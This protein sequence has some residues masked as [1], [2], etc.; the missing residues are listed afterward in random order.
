MDDLVRVSNASRHSI[1]SEFGGKRDLFLACFALYQKQ[2][3]TPAFAPVEAPDAG[4][5]EIE[6][7]F[8]MQISRAEK[9]GLP[10][11]GCLVANTATEYAP[12]DVDAAKEVKK[13]N[14]RLRSGFAN[15]LP[16]GAAEKAADTLVV[17][18][19]GLWTLSRIT[20]DAD[21]LRLT[22]AQFLKQFK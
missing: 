3:V 20:E 17:F 18:A 7:Y 12:H 21:H 15:A 5:A 11:P 19:T 22:S 14:D 16:E 9:S 1:Y 4:L 10:G 8:E 13:H 2:V 6:A